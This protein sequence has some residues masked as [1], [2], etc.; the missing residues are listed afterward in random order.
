MPGIVPRASV[1]RYLAAADVVVSPHANVDRFPGSPMKIFEY[2]ACGRA[3]I[4]SRLAQIGE[5]LRDEETALLVPPGD[6]A[7]LLAALERLYA[8]PA[9]RRSLGANAEAEARLQHSWAARVELIL[10]GAA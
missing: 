5:I 1:P 9:L 4:A 10:D 7:A 6:E 2:M 3:I 8:D